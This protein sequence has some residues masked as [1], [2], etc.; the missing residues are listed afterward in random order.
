MVVSLWLDQTSRLVVGIP[1]VTNVHRT[2][3]WIR[4]NV[5]CVSILTDLFDYLSIINLAWYHSKHDPWPY[6]V[7]KITK[8]TCV[9]NLPFKHEQNRQISSHREEILF[10]FMTICPHCQ[11]SQ[12]RPVETEGATR[13]GPRIPWKEGAVKKECVQRVREI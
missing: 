5:S 3:P 7:A 6:I 4:Y 1:K 12:S 2:K 9:A 11:S 8:N 10:A 13:S